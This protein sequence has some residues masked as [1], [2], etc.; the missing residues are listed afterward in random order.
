MV[1]AYPGLLLSNYRGGGGRFVVP[2]FAAELVLDEFGQFLIREGDFDPEEPARP[3]VEGVTEG[4]T[5]TTALSIPAPP[6]LAVGDSVLLVCGYDGSGVGF[7]TPSGIPKIMDVQRGTAGRLQVFWQ[8]LDDAGDF[9]ASYAL[10]ASSAGNHMGFALRISGASFASPTTAT[11]A[12]SSAVSPQTSS[13]SVAALD[14][15]LVIRAIT[16]SRSVS[17][18]TWVAPPGTETVEFAEV[19]GGPVTSTLVVQEPVP[20]PPGVRPAGT[21]PAK[22]WVPAVAAAYASGT[23]TIG[24]AVNPPQTLAGASGGS[25]STSADLSVTLRTDSLVT[26]VGTP[27]TGAVLSSDSNLTIATVAAAQPGDLLIALTAFRNTSAGFA[28][29]TGW[30]LVAVQP[31][32]GPSGTL[33][34]WSRVV[35]LGE[36]NAF[37]WTNSLA[38]QN[39]VGSMMAFRG[40]T[41]I[42]AVAVNQQVGTLPNLTSP[43][44]TP[45]KQWTRILRGFVVH[46]DQVLVSTATWPAGM[47]EKVDFGNAGNA[48]SCVTMAT[49]VQQAAASTGTVSVAESSAFVARWCGFTL[50]LAGD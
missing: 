22:S 30:S 32:T 6:A 31:E 11:S 19:G 42:N 48:G 47:T 10:T 34:V 45:T 9:L 26:E 39:Q 15:S 27:T 21:G 25:S 17:P 36:P 43:A 16:G 41:E 7:G 29:P 23:I 33:Q 3:R 35:G 49:T 8:N 20:A 13:A 4:I 5:Q 44:A 14:N 28:P 46:L 18:M 2:D 38:S 24:P 37:T 1:V 12:N 40:V 50:A